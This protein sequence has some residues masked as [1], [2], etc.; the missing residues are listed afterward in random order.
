MSLH[1]CEGLAQQ[2]EQPCLVQARRTELRLA[3]D[4]GLSEG[5]RI[6]PNVRKKSSEHPLVFHRLL[7]TAFLPLQIDPRSPPT[8]QG[9]LEQHPRITP[10]VSRSIS[11]LVKPWALRFTNLLS[12]NLFLRPLLYPAPLLGWSCSSTKDSLRRGHVWIHAPPDGSGLLASASSPS[13]PLQPILLPL[14]VCYN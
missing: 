9:W 10:G 5:Q 6:R 4:S 13:N 11:Y 2:S 1:I 7:E 12:P 8:I 3:L 14:P